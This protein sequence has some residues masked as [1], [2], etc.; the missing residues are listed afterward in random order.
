LFKE[1]KERPYD[2]LV[3]AKG[4]GPDG[5]G[6]RKLEVFHCERGVVYSR[7]FDR[8]ERKYV[9]QQEQLLADGFGC[10][11]THIKSRIHAHQDF[12]VWFY[13]AEEQEFVINGVVRLF[14][15]DSANER[16]VEK[17]KEVGL[18]SGAES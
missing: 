10:L 12:Q 4:I 16:A 2:L 14:G 6:A 17:L 1:L 13:T 5:M 18:T 8:S 15:S 11:L 9:G 7:I 3:T